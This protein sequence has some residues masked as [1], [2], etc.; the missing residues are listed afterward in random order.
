ML[1]IKS[2]RI[3]PGVKLV[4][5]GCRT[6]LGRRCGRKLIQQGQN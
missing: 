6:A 2:A 5:W 4:D 3:F 1:R